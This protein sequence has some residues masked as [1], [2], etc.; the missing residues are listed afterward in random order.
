MAKPKRERF[1]SPKGIAKYPRLQKPDTK[2]VA[3]GEY[4]IGLILD[5]SN[6]ADAAFLAELEAKSKKAFT[7]AKAELKEKKKAKLLKELTLNMP[8]EDVLDDEGDAT[9]KVEVKFK[10]KAHVKPKNGDAFDQKP[11]LFDSKGKPYVG[12]TIGGGST[13][14]V[15][16]EV[17]EY[18]NASAKNAGI[19]LRLRAVKVID[20]VEYSSGGDASSYG[21]D[22]DDDE[23]YES[24]ESSDESDDTDEGDDDEGEDDNDDF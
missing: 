15:S 2:F 6:K 9:G 5:R 14:R 23:G 17:I 8:F 4:K 12:P 1:G 7:E 24:G 16:F 11:A 20:L 3:E 10:L 21:F 13:V 19:S 18:C 22:D